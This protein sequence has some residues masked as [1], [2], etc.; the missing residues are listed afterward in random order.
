[1]GSFL[2]GLS[3]LRQRSDRSRWSPRPASD[4]RGGICESTIRSVFA[5]P[6]FAPSKLKNKLMFLIDIWCASK[7]YAFTLY[8]LLFGGRTG[9]PKKVSLFRLPVLMDAPFPGA[10]RYL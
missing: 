1:M 5:K 9:S 2:E 4:E 8:Y 10:S 7:L 6:F 3:P